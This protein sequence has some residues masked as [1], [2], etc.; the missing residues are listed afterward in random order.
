M[1][2]KLYL[3]AVLSFQ[4]FIGNQ[5]ATR[6]QDNPDIHVVVNMVQL[7]VAVTDNKGNYI[8]GLR[9]SDFAIYELSRF[10]NEKP[11][12]NITPEQIEKIS[13]GTLNPKDIPQLRRWAA[14]FVCVLRP[15]RQPDQR[16]VQVAHGVFALP[17]QHRA[18]SRLR[19]F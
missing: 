1:G 12:R 15:S 17:A 6:A 11:F 18:F 3:A 8:T 16:S 7:N 9:P 14:D 19:A 13:T 2:R 5:T 4:L 10:G